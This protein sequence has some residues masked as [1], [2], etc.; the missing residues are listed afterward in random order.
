MSEAAPWTR[1]RLMWTE[2]AKVAKW[3]G[4][5]VALTEPP[6]ITGR[7]VAYLDFTPFVI[8]QIRFDTEGEREMYGDEAMEALRMLKALTE[9]R[10]DEQ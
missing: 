6:I 10:K 4:V 8:A 2:R 3:D 1:R 7:K 9:H 5:S